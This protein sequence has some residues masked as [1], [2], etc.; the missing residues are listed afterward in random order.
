[1][2]AELLALLRDSSLAITLALLAVLALRRPIRSVFGAGCVPLLWALVPL[3]QLAV[4]LP[5][6]RTSH[7]TTW[8]TL[9]LETMPGAVVAEAMPALVQNWSWQPWLLAIWLAG[10]L[11]MTLHLCLLQRRFLRSLGPL[12][13]LSPGVFIAAHTDAGPAV[14]GLWRPR[15]VLP[16]D[17]HQRF[18]PQQQI[19]ILSHE[20][21]HARRGDVIAQAIASVLR[22]IHWFNP[23]LHVAVP[24]LRHDHELASDADVL[25]QYPDSRRRY[26]AT[27]L[28]AQ[29]AVPGLPAGCL[30]QSSHPLKERIMLLKNVQPSRLRRHSG[31]ALALALACGGSFAV[32]A[33]QPTQPA[34]STAPT[35]YL[36]NMEVALGDSVSTPELIVTAGKPFSIGI[37]NNTDG[38]GWR[39]EFV[40]DGDTGQLTRAD[41]EVDG[42]LEVDSTLLD[43]LNAGHTVQLTTTGGE[44]LSLRI[45]VSVPPDSDIRRVDTPAPAYPAQAAAQD[46][47]GRI[48]LKVKVDELGRAADIEVEASEPAGVFDAAAV[49]AVQDWRFRPAIRDGKPIE[50]WVRVPIC[51]APDGASEESCEV[52]QFGNPPESPATSGG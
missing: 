51:F 11:A 52:A 24:R 13:P 18:T 40:Y 43:A 10:A 5:A 25:R 22:C 9:P 8:I 6:P 12:T 26:A 45:A 17:F 49:A 33:G 4:L 30:W 2:S 31:L 28:D 48:L 38:G 21:S 1:M 37:G 23:L 35:L 20:R 46:Q 14:I 42:T 36:V 47:G 27:L 41:I 15:I 34:A 32:W 16:A 7:A 29:L 39:G 3:A 50:S 44:E 19:L